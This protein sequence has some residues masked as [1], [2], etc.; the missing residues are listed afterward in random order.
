M[1]LLGIVI[2]V[3]AI[4][5]LIKI[6]DLLLKEGKKKADRIDMLKK[7]LNNQSDT[8]I[9]FDERIADTIH[10]FFLVG[11]R[12]YTSN[13]QS[14]YNE[15]ISIIESMRSTLYLM[16]ETNRQLVAESRRQDQSAAISSVEAIIT[17]AMRTAEGFRKFGVIVYTLPPTMMMEQNGYGRIDKAYWNSICS[18]HRADVVNYISNCEALLESTHY[19]ELYAIDIRKIVECLWFFA[20]EK[21]FS[22]NDYK[23]SEVLFARIYKH[24]HADPIIAGLYAKKKLGGEA[25]LRDSVRDILNNQRDYNILALVASGLMWICAYET[26]H[27]VLQHM[28]THNMEMS[29]KIQERLYSLTNGGGKAPSGFDVNS[30]TGLLYFD[31][32]ALA[33]R[34]DEYNGLFENLA[35]QDKKLTYSLAVRDENKEG[36]VAK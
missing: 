36:T 5:L 12:F 25:V 32:S 13:Y 6:A 16:K 34:D 1:G 31:V 22:A 29:S 28:L 7:K 11:N 10:G 15:L 35:F 3:G 27:I 21:T 2:V 26:E 9:R 19:D 23:R 33:W 4:L 24:S 20:T 17:Q 8:L 18:M 14:I 30:S